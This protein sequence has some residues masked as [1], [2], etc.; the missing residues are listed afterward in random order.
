M[1]KSLAKRCYIHVKGCI[2]LIAMSFLFLNKVV[3]SQ[4]KRKASAYNTDF[5]VHTHGA[6]MT[7][8]NI[9][10]NNLIWSLERDTQPNHNI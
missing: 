2:P 8:V 3:D 4:C 5:C 6:G 1:K 7:L 10:T 9:R